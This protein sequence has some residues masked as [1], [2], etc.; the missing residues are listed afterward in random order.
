MQ[1]RDQPF[2][3]CHALWN[4]FLLCEAQVQLNEMLLSFLQELFA[5]VGRI[6]ARNKTCIVLLRT[7]IPMS[8]YCPTSLQVCLATL[9]S[10]SPLMWHPFSACFHAAYAVRLSPLV[11]LFHFC[12]CCWKSIPP[13]VPWSF[14][15]WSSNC[16]AFPRGTEPFQWWE[17]IY[18]LCSELCAWKGRVCGLGF[19]LHCYW[20]L[21]FS[22]FFLHCLFFFFLIKLVSTDFV[23][24]G[25][26]LLQDSWGL[27]GVR[28]LHAYSEI[29]PLIQL[30]SSSWIQSHLYSYCPGF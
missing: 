6:L 17:I 3:C 30:N 1:N 12:W 11:L 15:F 8:L 18:F 4:S 7:W 23:V 28:F 13:H 29:V 24:L 9:V 19:N 14:L 10:F 2:L 5:P 27:A 20:F 25:S 22:I 21:P 26:F 16:F